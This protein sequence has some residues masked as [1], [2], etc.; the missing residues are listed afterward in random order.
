[1][2]DTI[3]VEG[4]VIEKREGRRPDAGRVFW[5]HVITNQRGEAVMEFEINRLMKKRGGL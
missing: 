5:R 4:E 1:V 3:R 2:G